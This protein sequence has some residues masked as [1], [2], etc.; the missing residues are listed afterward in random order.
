M[1]G[2]GGMGGAP[3]TEAP[4]LEVVGGKGMRGAPPI[5]ALAPGK[6]MEG[7][8]GAPPIRALTPK[9][10]PG[11]D[12]GGIGGAPLAGAS[13][14]EAVRGGGMGGAPLTG[15][16][17]VELVPG[18]GKGGAWPMRPLAS[19]VGREKGV[20]KKRESV[21]TWPTVRPLVDAWGIN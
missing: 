17:P 1:G 9:P 2:M 7:M 11:E 5:K 6:S 15:S 16:L 10:G 3:P 4:A 18:K 20:Q 19:G 14:L 13:E 8:G 12:V 21:L